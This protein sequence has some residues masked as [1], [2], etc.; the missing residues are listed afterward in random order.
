MIDPKQILIQ[1]KLKA[2]RDS[3]S[4]AEFL[5][6]ADAAGIDGGGL[7]PCLVDIDGEDNATIIIADGPFTGE[8]MVVPSEHIISINKDD[9]SEAA[10]KLFK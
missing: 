6:N 5:V 9:V 8:S 7:L 10:N 2:L 3:A 1:E 4:K